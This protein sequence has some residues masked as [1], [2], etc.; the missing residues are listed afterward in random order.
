[1]KPWPECKNCGEP[2]GAHKATGKP[3]QYCSDECM[4]EWGAYTGS[5]GGRKNIRNLVPH[6]PLCWHCRKRPRSAIH[7]GAKL[8][9][10]SEA[11]RQYRADKRS[12]REAGTEVP[13]P[14]LLYKYCSVQCREEHL[15]PIK[16][17][18]NFFYDVDNLDMFE[19][20]GDVPVSDLLD[21]ALDFARRHDF[22]SIFIDN[23]HEEGSDRG[24]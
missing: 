15:A 19:V 5:Y 6:W 22:K 1:M 23:T 4:T 13:H 18:L 24:L 10:Y 16:D 14:T 11:V 12:A 3:R 20:L 17:C 21:K 8:P 9:E 2:A 7:V